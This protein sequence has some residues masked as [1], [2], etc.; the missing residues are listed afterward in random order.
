MSD[1]E[2]IRIRQLDDRSKYALCRSTS[3]PPSALKATS[4]PSTPTASSMLTTTTSYTR[5]TSSSQRSATKNLSLYAPTLYN[6]SVQLLRSTSSPTH[7]SP[8][9]LSPRYLSLYRH[10]T[11]VFVRTFQRTSTTWLHLSSL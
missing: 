4:I 2:G 11:A 10:D 1:L 3:R 7:S 9:R 5:A 6:R 8:R